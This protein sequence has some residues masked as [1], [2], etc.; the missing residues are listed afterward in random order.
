MDSFRVQ[1]AAFA[2]YAEARGSSQQVRAARFAVGSVLVLVAVFGVA[3]WFLIVPGVRRRRAQ[4]H[5]ET[6]YQHDQHEFSESVQATDSEDEAHSLLK[7][8]LEL[9]IPES[10]VTILRRNHSDDRL[11]PATVVAPDSQ[12]SRSLES[13]APRSCLA[14]RLGHVHDENPDRPQLMTCELCGAT[15]RQV[16]CSPLLVA[17]QVIGSVLVERDDL[18]DQAT[19]RRVADSVDRAAPVTA[20][21]R[22]LALAEARASTDALTGLANRRSADDTLKRMVAHARRAGL[23]LV[24]V[25]FDLDHFKDINDRFGHE[26]GDNVLAA[27]SEAARHTLRASDF[28]GRTGGEE[29]IVLLPDTDLS[30]GVVAA[31]K[32]REAIG[33]IDVVG[34][35]RGTTASFGVAAFPEHAREPET[36]LRQADR[37]L[38]LAKQHGRN[39]V[40]AATQAGVAPDAATPVSADPAANGR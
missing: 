29:F 4:R 7:R 32:L 16:T 15:G 19:R 13:A 6:A 27:A 14:V 17:G 10:Q 18:L 38:Y 31:E 12:F 20:N 1:N 11:E 8:H 28:V 3:A 9:S 24:A 34:V 25:M 30:G 22:N 40:E 39:R 33:A 21:L 36:L 35:E 37:A 23:P 2:R 5:D 26:Q